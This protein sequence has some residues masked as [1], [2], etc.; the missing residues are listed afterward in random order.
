MTSS[1]IKD[2]TGASLGEDREL[3]QGSFTPKEPVLGLE[4][5]STQASYVTRRL[6]EKKVGQMRGNYEA[7]L[8]K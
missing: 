4:S 7:I 1:V 6:A 5:I 8:E 2:T 3:M